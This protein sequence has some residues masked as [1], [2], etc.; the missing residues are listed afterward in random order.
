MPIPQGFDI[1]D[2]ACPVCGGGMWDNRDSKRKPTQPDFKCK[3]KDCRDGA[4]W[5]ESR[6]K[7]G[8]APRPAAAPRSAAP[9]S[10]P[11]PQGRAGAISWNDALGA[12]GEAVVVMAEALAGVAKA[13]GLTLTEPTVQ[14]AYLDAVQKMATTYV[15]ALADGKLRSGAEPPPPLSAKDQYRQRLTN[16]PESKAV[17]AVIRAFSSDAALTADEKD[18][19]GKYADE[20]LETISL[21]DQLPG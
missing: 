9:V 2:P 14:A 18:E 1:N 12:G 7:G 19:L 4:V 20:R 10:T 5:L 15:I 11:A 13:H 6:G 16:A 21:S 3:D 17:S 8:N